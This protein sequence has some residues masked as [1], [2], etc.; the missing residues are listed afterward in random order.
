[1]R[2][3]SLILNIVNSVIGGGSVCLAT[4][5]SPTIW[6]GASAK[7]LTG[8]QPVGGLLALSAQA[9]AFFVSCLPFI[10]LLSIIMGWILF[11]IKK[12]K[13]AT[14]VGIF[15]VIVIALS[16]LFFLMFVGLSI[17]SG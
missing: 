11:G 13:I 12:Y 17:I 4:M 3:I 14:I 5:V 15:P 2:E 7:H 16:I 10:V 9:A 6:S 1:M 8:P